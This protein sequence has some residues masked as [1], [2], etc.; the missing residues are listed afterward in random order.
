MSNKLKWPLANS[1]EVL[2]S[3]RKVALWEAAN[4]L[5]AIRRTSSRQAGQVKKGC[6]DNAHSNAKKGKTR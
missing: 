3:Y 1:Q 5:L 4:G 6:P 2:E